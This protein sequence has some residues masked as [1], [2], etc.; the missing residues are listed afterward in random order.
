MS[1]QAVNETTY[2]FTTI[3]ARTERGGRVTRM[4]TNATI[5][6]LGLAVVGDI[7]GHEEGAAAMIADGVGCAVMWRG[8]PVTVAESHSS[9]GD[10]IVTAAPDACGITVRDGEEIPRLLES[11]YSPIFADVVRPGGGGA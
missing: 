4:S 8:R 11:A 7:R 3:G 10:R 5:D 9:N 1:E 6:K 2:L